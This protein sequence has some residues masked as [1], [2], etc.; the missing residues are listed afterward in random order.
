[1]GRLPTT[2]KTDNAIM[3]FIKRTVLL[4]LILAIVGLLSLNYYE[5]SFTVTDGSDAIAGAT[6]SLDGYGDAI[7][8]AAGEVIFFNVTLIS[9]IAYTVTGAGYTDTTGILTASLANESFQVSESVRCTEGISSGGSDTDIDILNIYPNPA[10]T[11][12]NVSGSTGL[13]Y[14]YNLTGTMVLS[15]DLSQSTS[16]NISG[17]SHGVYLLKVDGGVMQVVKE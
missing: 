9:A 2:L 10:T 16:I 5:V 11:T 4:F 6:V 8:D 14:L 12:L 17:L 3:E 1:M 15:Q 13:A 7:T